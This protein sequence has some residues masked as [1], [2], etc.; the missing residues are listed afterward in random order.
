[1]IIETIALAL[2][3]LVPA[4]RAKQ[5]TIEETR[6]EIARAEIEE[7]RR[8]LHDAR[9]ASH[10]WADYALTL[11][12]QLDAE[13]A[14]PMQMYQQQAL[15]A[16]MANAQMAQLQAQQMAGMQNAYNG[17]CQPLGSLATNP[18]AFC[19]CVPARHDMLLGPRP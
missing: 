18:Q 13:R 12:R 7:L 6:A 16:Q 15:N 17:L 4:A 5:A 8:K 2:Q 11:Q 10:A 14:H 1:M 3:A 9:A 19:N